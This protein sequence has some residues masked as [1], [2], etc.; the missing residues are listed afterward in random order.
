MPPS[1]AHRVRPKTKTVARD[2]DMHQTKKGNQ[3][4]IGMKAHIGIDSQ[5]KQIHSV[6][7]TAANVRDSQ[8]LED[9]LHGDET[10]VW[11]DSASAGQ[12][13]VMREHAPHAQ[14]FTHEKGCRNKPLDDAAKGRNR[15][16]SKVRAKVEHDFGVIKCVFGFTKVR[17]RG[18][19]KNANA[20][21]VLC[22]LTNLYMA[23]RRLRCPT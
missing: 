18:L 2:P 23:R 16:K 20:L 3:W 15:T 5:T 9:L 4:C 17:Y 14:D 21:F 6:A 7:A 1:S 22:A 13:A 12:T 19:D 8:V 10:R 11:G